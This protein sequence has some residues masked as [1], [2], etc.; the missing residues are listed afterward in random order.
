MSC[1]LSVWNYGKWQFYVNIDLGS[2]NTTIDPQE[3]VTIANNPVS[4]S[5][6]DKVSISAHSRFRVPIFHADRNRLGKCNNNGTTGR[7][8]G[9]YEFP[10]QD[11]PRP[12]IHDIT[13]CSRHVRGTDTFSNNHKWAEEAGSESELANKTQYCCVGIRTEY[14]HFYV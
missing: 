14:I 7:R 13:S 1:N 5:L 2:L 9:N 6:R 11:R 8:L 10:S 3:L 12:G 4:N